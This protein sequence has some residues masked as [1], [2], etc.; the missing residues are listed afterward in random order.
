MSNKIVILPKRTIANPPVKTVAPVSDPTKVKR[1]LQKVERCA[2]KSTEETTPP[3]SDCCSP[4][5]I[6]VV[7]K[8]SSSS[9]SDCKSCGSCSSSSSS[10]SSDCDDGT[11]DTPPGDAPPPSCVPGSCLPSSSGTVLCPQFTGPRGPRGVKGPKGNPTLVSYVSGSLKSIFSNTTDHVTGTP[12]VVAPS[13]LIH[14]L[15][16]NT[17]NGSLTGLINGNLPQLLTFVA[18]KNS[19]Y[20]ANVYV[21]MRDN[22]ASNNGNLRLIIR[23]YDVLNVLVREV[24]KNTGYQLSTIDSSDVTKSIYSVH[25]EHTFQLNTNEKMIFLIELSPFPGN[26]TSTFNPVDGYVKI[27]QHNNN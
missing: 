16:L 2:E 10:S 13:S 14:S 1:T 23:K 24:S 17:L 7:C 25:L 5:M 6:K 11:E 20:S 22:I 15:S 27:L 12:F 21:K 9:S 8:S 4:Q 19:L 3:T 18:P 26:V